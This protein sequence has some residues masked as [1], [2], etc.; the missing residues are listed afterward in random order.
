MGF[1]ARVTLSLL[2]VR[3]EQ[4]RLFTLGPSSN[5][6][7]SRRPAEATRLPP[8]P[9]PPGPSGR[10]FSPR[11]SFRVISGRVPVTKA[12]FN[13]LTPSPGRPWLARPTRRPARTRRLSTTGRSP[14]RND[15]RKALSRRSYNP[16]L[17]DASTGRHKA[18]CDSVI[19]RIQWGKAR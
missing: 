12:P 3:A 18:Q 10:S 1:P 14:R 7:R 19:A 17:N 8:S 15:T 6:Q 4:R 16:L 5:G 13:R 9:P 11:V 2:E